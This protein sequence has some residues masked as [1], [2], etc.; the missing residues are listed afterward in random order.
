MGLAQIDIVSL[1]PAANLERVK[2][3]IQSPG[4]AGVDLVIFPELVNTGQVPAWDE[5]FARKFFSIVEPLDGAFLDGVAD[6]ARQVEVHVVIGVAEQHPSVPHTVANSVV[7][8][9]PSGAILGVQ[10]KLHLPGEERHWF[11]AGDSVDVISTELGTLAVH[12][13]YDLYFPEVAR[14]SALAGAEILIG[15]ANI[16]YRESW[17]ERLTYL[18]SVRSYENMQP[19]VIVNRVGVDHDLRYAGGSV[20]ARPPGIIEYES[21]FFEPDTGRV[22]LD[23]S[24]LQEQRARR[25]IFADRR[26]ELYGPVVAPSFPVVKHG[27]DVS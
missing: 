22:V 10:R 8:L 12:I 19:V 18:A 21:P 16:P 14:V 11:G 17:A 9:D 3:A 7:V 27:K 2:E 23:G 13:C 1:D 26:P 5:R 15:V 6:L 24:A 20:V 4:L 25:P